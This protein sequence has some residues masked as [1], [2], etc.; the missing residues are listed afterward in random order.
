MQ[1]P[2]SRKP[3]GVCRFERR[4]S[5][6]QKRLGVI[7]RQPLLIAL[8]RHPGPAAEDALEMRRAHV[9]LGGERVERYRPRPVPVD[10]IERAADDGVVIGGVG[11]LVGHGRTFCSMP[12]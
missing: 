8:R 7:E 2:R 3:D 12:N 1:T 10:K 11:A 4:M 5:F 6:R 9:H